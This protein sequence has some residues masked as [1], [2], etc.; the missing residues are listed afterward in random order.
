VEEAY[1]RAVASEGKAEP[2]D[3]AAYHYL[4]STEQVQTWVRQAGLEI[5][6]EEWEDSLPTRPFFAR[7]K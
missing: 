3:V 2:E 7:K 4:P 1:K 6:D 5:E